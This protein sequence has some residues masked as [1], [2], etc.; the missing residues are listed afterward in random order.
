MPK[1]PLFR[2]VD[3]RRRVRDGSGGRHGA[4]A[5]DAAVKDAAVKNVSAET[6]GKWTRGPPHAHA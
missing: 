6:S 2:S 3:P 4:K 1:K 5:L